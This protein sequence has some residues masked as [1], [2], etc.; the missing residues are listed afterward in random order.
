M[1]Y[2]DESTIYI[3]ESLQKELIYSDIVTFKVLNPDIAT[4]IYCGKSYNLNSDIYRYRSYKSWLDM[5]QI[6][7]CKMLTPK[8]L[9]SL[10]ELTFKKLN[11]FS[12]HTK[13]EDDKYGVDSEFA[14]INKLQEPS[15]IYY[16]IEALKRVDIYNRKRVLNLGIN[17]GDEFI[18]IKG[19]L[20]DKTFNNI[21]FVG[22]DYSN[23]ALELANSRFKESNVTFYKHDIN[24]VKELNLGRFDTLISIGTMQSSSINYKALLMELVQEHLEN[25]SAIILGFPNS[26]WIGGELI[27]GAEVKNY[28]FSE[29]GLLYSDVIFAKKYLQQKK[30]RVTITGKDYIF[31]TATKIRSALV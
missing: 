23:S 6:L 4:D 21:D 13:V 30:Y 22:I 19:L 31:L 16:Y 28:N 18:A 29:M 10:V 8:N 9:G 17:R 7:K 14:N 2:K 12:F 5:A 11:K 25:N 27:Y 3:I 24:R 15:F 1:H 26:R 20:E